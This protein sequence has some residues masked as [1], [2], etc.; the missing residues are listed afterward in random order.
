[1]DNIVDLIVTDDES[2]DS[3]NLSDV[4]QELLS[5]NRGSNYEFIGAQQRLLDERRAQ[6]HID[7]RNKYFTPPLSHHIITVAIADGDPKPFK[8]ILGND[9]GTSNAFNYGFAIDRVIG[10]KMLN[11]M[12]HHNVSHGDYID[13]TIPEIPYIACTKNAERAPLIQRLKVVSSSN[14]LYYENKYAFHNLYF[15]P[16][17]LSTLTID[18]KDVDGNTPTHAYI[19]FEIT[20][21][22]H[23]G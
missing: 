4:S 2:S 1:M 17:K 8:V 19:D 11:A 22:N 18:M 23:E 7:F 12:V 20:T 14:F 13:I 15:T 3:D 21:L 6:E 16:I 10:F 5:T 9:S